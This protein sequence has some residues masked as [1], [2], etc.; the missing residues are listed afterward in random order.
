[1]Q[2]VVR[3]ALQPPQTNPHRVALARHQLTGTMALA[4]FELAHVGLAVLCPRS[5]P[6]RRALSVAGADVA[7]VRCWAKPIP[8]LVVIVEADFNSSRRWQIG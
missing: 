5:E 2:Y 1:M 4:V 7:V 8:C 6:V 3:S